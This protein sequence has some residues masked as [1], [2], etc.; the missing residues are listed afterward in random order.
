MVVGRVGEVWCVACL[1]C[2]QCTIL[3]CQRED[4]QAIEWS[5]HDESLSWKV[6]GRDGALARNG[7]ESLVCQ[8]KVLGRLAWLVWHS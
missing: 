4:K 8:V 2:H 1:T 3:G 6:W 7:K 5:S